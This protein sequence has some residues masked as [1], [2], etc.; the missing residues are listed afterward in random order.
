[1]HAPS[2][3]GTKSIMR[4][5]PKALVSGLML[6]ACSFTAAAD[7]VTG[8]VTDEHGDPLAGVSVT[9]KGKKTGVTTD[10]DGKYSI[11]APANATLSYH[12]VGMV[13]KDV[14]VAGN[15]NINVT[16][17]EDTEVL[18]EV[19]VVGYGQQKKATMTGAVSQVTAKDIVKSTGSN[20]SQALVGKLPGVISSQSTGR[21]G[22]DNVSFLVRGYS[23][24][25]DSGTVLTII[26]GVDRG[27]TGLAGI[28]PN[29]V[30][31]ITVLKDAA[32][33]AIYGM[34]ASNGV[35][36]VTTKRGQEGKT[37][38]NYRGTLTLS[39]A[40]MMP[41]MMN[42]TQYMQWYNL[43]R[44]MDGL[45]PWFTDEDIAATTNGDLTDGIENTDWT[46]PMFKT[47]LMTQH[48]LSISGGTNRTQYYISG[49]YLKQ[50]GTLDGQ[51]YQ[52][53]TF[54]SNINTQIGKMFEV[55]FNVGGLVGDSYYPSGQALNTTGVG[56][57]D[58]EN[59][60]LYSVP[61]I[62]KTYYSS[63]PD[64]PYNGMPTTAF[65]NMG[66]NPEY[67]VQDSNSGFSQ[68]R[69]V[70]INT[71]GRIDWKAPF[72]KGL[73]ASFFFSWDWGDVYG[74]TFSYAYKVM[75]WNPGTKTYYYTNCANLLENGNMYVGDS[76][77]QQI[78]IRPQI[79]Y[80][81]QFNGV[82]NVNA[83]VVYEQTRGKSSALTGQRTDFALFDLPELSYGQTISTSNGNSGSSGNSA[84]E[85]WAGRFSYNYDQKYLAEFAFRY[86]GSYLFA[87]GNRY[88][89]FPSGSLGWVI[90]REDWFKERFP[91][92]DIL[93]LRGS[94]GMMGNDNV[95]AYLYRK[96]YGWI[97]NG[98]AFGDT[99]TAQKT[100]YQNVAY[101][102][103]DLTWEKTRT[104]DI[105]VET[106]LW[107]GLLSVEF[108]WFYKYTY[109]ILQSVSGAYAPS[110]AGNY[111]TI[112]NTGSFDNR[113]L[114][115]VL[116][117]TNHIGDFYYNLNGNFSWAHN[118]Y[119]KR[120]QSSGT[121]PWQTTLGAS[122]GDVWGLKAIGLYQ[123]EEQLANAPKPIN[124]TPHLGDIMYED[125]NGDGKITSADYVK[126]G[127]TGMP[128]IMFS[129][130]ADANWRGFDFSM[131][132][133]G[134]AKNDKFLG[135]SGGSD[136]TPLTRPWYGGTDNSPLFLV[137]NSWRPD[138]TD[139]EYPR[140]TTLS[141]GNNAYR[142]TFWKRNG[143][144]LR[145]KNVSIGY[146]IPKR[147]TNKAG[148]ANLRAFV[149][150]MNL[151]T[152]TEYKFID[153]E[154]NSYAWSF[155]P[156]QRT[157]TFGLDLSF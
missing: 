51:N 110:L 6:L 73:K 124:T 113:G 116:R 21:P 100:L 89:F 147:I 157:F 63:D 131:Q 25:N 3:K 148:I 8:V 59:Q 137:E 115:L 64:D 104:Y 72:L 128:E 47:T 54:R 38:I 92:V 44:E 114:E 96:S 70:T 118:R 140:L 90:S 65:R 121:L 117:H 80:D 18:G 48:N 87:P 108:D 126:I 17:G 7:N 135:W 41:K 78:V 127:H 98:V 136:Y 112:D 134:A 111:P 16:L 76:R 43:A 83:V 143:A 105:G 39:H 10:I 12:L 19:V 139:A 149:S 97:T 103:S 155:Y 71:A 138:N 152:F 119:I 50:D 61:Y 154:I 94:I 144:Y 1:M 46:S 106:T 86:D 77:S 67:A 29:D 53:G 2:D 37:N 26:D 81:A 49:G 122:M 141:C 79:S 5:S 156:Q 9:I 132:W 14:K 102:Q 93:K 23:S 11:D 82:H 99:P 95:T 85:G 33:C 120:T 22:Y 57:Y 75:S 101:P 69:R 30:E 153:P 109:D 151:L 34:K 15:S 52:K 55:Q 24:Y 123:T 60:M 28:D 35:I 142:S 150:G 45:T 107:N 145:L 42:G 56:G 4:P 88:G 40:T 66:H 36:I 27:S 125:V 13:H 62:P 84:S 32:S 146:T 129:F 68:T 58:L 130:T 20:L 133:Q 31:S 74:K 91:N